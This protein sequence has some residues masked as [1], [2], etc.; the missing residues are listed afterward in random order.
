MPTGRLKCSQV[1]EEKK[2]LML[3]IAA[4]IIVDHNKHGLKYKSTVIEKI[5]NTKNKLKG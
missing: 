1:V 2:I 3:E 4:N 5:I